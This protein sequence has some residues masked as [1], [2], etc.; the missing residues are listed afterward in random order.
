MTA[1]MMEACEYTYVKRQVFGLT[2]LDLECYKALQVQRR[3]MTYLADRFES[4]FDLI[5]CRNV[6]I[7]F[8]ASDFTRRCVL[9]VCYLWAVP[10]LCSM[11]PTWGLKQ[12]ASL[13]IVA[14]SKRLD[15]VSGRGKTCHWCS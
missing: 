7:Y 9:V 12:P 10:R 1:T 13:F 11:Q 5:V 15:Y 6:T 3:L 14:E 4:G 8:T 2:G